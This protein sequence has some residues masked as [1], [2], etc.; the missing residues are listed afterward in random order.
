MIQIYDGEKYCTVYKLSGV[1]YI[2]MIIAIL[3]Y[4]SVALE[5]NSLTSFGL[6]IGFFEG[7]G[8][9]E[10]FTN[11]FKIKTICA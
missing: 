9:C 5:K 11:T 3:H 7:S 6:C 10:A 2:S 4:L 8:K 1:E